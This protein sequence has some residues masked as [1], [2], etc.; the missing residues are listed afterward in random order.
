LRETGENA[1]IFPS[2]YKVKEERKMTPSSSRWGQ[3]V[4]QSCGAAAVHRDEQYPPIGPIKG[5]EI[6]FDS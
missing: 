2:K 5:Q 3:L 1:S 4:L 6:G